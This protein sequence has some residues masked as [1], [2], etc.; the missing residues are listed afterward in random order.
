MELLT[1]I[2]QIHLWAK[3]DHRTFVIEH[4]RPWHEA[5]DKN[6]LLEWKSRYDIEEH[7]KE[8]RQLNENQDLNVPSWVSRFGEA[9]QRNIQLRAS[10]TL[11]GALV[12][13]SRIK[14]KGK[15]VPTE[16]EKDEGVFHC[17]VDGCT[18][19]IRF[20]C[21]WLDH[22]ETTHG[23]TQKALAQIRDGINRQE[24]IGDIEERREQNITATGRRW[25]FPWA[26]KD[27]T[28]TSAQLRVLCR[29]RPD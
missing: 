23:M 19:I 17:A 27:N 16:D 14:G 12:T 13:H 29:G 4:L 22:L 21:A 18:S 15:A 28:L 26:L 24:L 2:D 6:F 11:I 5:C 1:L 9:F 7:L 10:K 3:T 25:A 8:E 20:S